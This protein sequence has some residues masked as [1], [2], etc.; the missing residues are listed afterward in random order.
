MRFLVSV[1]PGHGHLLPMVPV[2]RKLKQSGHSVVITTSRS[3]LPKVRQYIDS[4][5]IDIGLDWNEADAVAEGKLHFIGEEWPLSIV[6]DLRKVIRE[7]SIDAVIHGP[8]DPGAW[9]ASELENVP[10]VCV[11]Y[12]VRQVSIP[13]IGGNDTPERKAQR[14]RYLAN[15]SWSHVRSKFGLPPRANF[16][17]D[18]PGDDQLTL[19]L[20]A[21]SLHP[22]P[23]EM[24]MKPVVECRL[25]FVVR[26]REGTTEVVKRLDPSRPV[27]HFAL[28]SLYQP[29][30]WGWAEELLRRDP[31]MQLVVTG[32]PP[33][34]LLDKGVIA[35]DWLD[36]SLLLPHVDVFVHH[37][38]WGSMMA[39]LAHGVPSVVYPMFGDQSYNASRLQMLGAAYPLWFGEGNFGTAQ[40]WADAI[41]LVSSNDRIRGVCQRFQEEIQELE[42]IDSAV[43]LIEKLASQPRAAG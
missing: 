21:P 25:E 7:R 10:E 37:A 13:S 2:A 35:R 43:P 17:S 15:G 19:D 24:N 36:H 18:F 39:A 14:L 6:E 29:S 5:C 34:E 12:S 27:V 38:G 30:H 31:R 33:R 3:F 20:T 8:F 28:G 41:L 4:D 16:F 1:I 22:F 9:V 26:D 40:E 32:R 11:G 23:V 42:P